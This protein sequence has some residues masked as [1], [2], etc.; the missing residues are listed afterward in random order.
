M[1]RT[2]G[3]GV[4]TKRLKKIIT[5]IIA[6][7]ILST[8]VFA[9]NTTKS[10]K[11]VQNANMNVDEVLSMQHNQDFKKLVAS[12]KAQKP[13]SE[14][15][16]EL[17]YE[18]GYFIRIYQ[19][20]PKEIEYI[21]KLVLDGYDLDKLIQIYKFWLDTD[22][23]ITLLQRIYDQYGSLYQEDTNW[24][25]TAFNQMT[26][27]AY[28]VLDREQIHA[29]YEKGLTRDDIVTANRLCRMGQWTI[30]KILDQKVSG[31]SWVEIIAQIYGQSAKKDTFNLSPSQIQAFQKIER[32]KEILDALFL[33]RRTAEDIHHYLDKLAKGESLRPDM[34]QYTRQQTQGLLTGLKAQGLWD[35]P[36]DIKENNDK[37]RR[38]L[39]Q[40]IL[41]SGV[42]AKEMEALKKQ[43]YGELDILNAS[44]LSKAR[45]TEVNKVLEGKKQGKTWRQIIEKGVN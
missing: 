15:F 18:Y 31:M 17:M 41:D 30:Q 7:W 13:N 14:A 34:Q 24:V 42:S 29:Y 5:A 32:G 9:V 45:R 28:G 25:E 44:R 20:T 22:E 4:K 36:A 10:G 8:V 35:E 11:E 23:D 39:Q 27:S 40:Q 21:E 2:G 38:Y 1:I 33:S 3:I 26:G 6:G 43:G 37:V 12:V 16:Y 19:P